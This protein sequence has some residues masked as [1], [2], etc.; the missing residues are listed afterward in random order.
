MAN[1]YKTGDL[2]RLKSGSKVMTVV[3]VDGEAV[4]CRWFNESAGSF[5]TETFPYE[6]VD[7]HTP[8]R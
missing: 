7:R 3:G 5:P 1:P 2:V 4:T 8:T 6:A